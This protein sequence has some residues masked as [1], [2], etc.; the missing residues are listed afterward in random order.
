LSFADV[1]D[2]LCVVVALLNRILLQIADGL[3]NLNQKMFT[4]DQVKSISTM[5]PSRDDVR[6]R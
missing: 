6:K 3:K 4:L 1:I 2:F 5:L